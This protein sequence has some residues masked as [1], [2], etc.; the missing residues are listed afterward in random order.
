MRRV[1]E[2]RT[3]FEL[4]GC[5]GAVRAAQENPCAEQV[6]ARQSH[7]RCV[8]ETSFVIRK[9]ILQSEAPSRDEMGALKR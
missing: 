7:P 5:T 1:A 9:H 4:F 8:V 2:R 3:T 6:V